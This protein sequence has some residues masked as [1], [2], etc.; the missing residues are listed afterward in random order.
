MPRVA[1]TISGRHAIHPSSSG[2]TT[3]VQH[4]EDTGNGPT[5]PQ[6][7]RNTNAEK[8]SSGIDLRHPWV[9]SAIYELPFGRQNG[10]LGQNAATRAILGGWQLRGFSIESPLTAKAQRH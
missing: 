8:A 10:W 7:P 3:T 2:R 9:T 4:G 5:N 6:D 1:E